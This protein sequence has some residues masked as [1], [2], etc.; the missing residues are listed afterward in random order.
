MLTQKQTI[1]V[2]RQQQN[3]VI[4]TRGSSGMGYSIPRKK[5][6][7]PGDF[8]LKSWD[9]Y[10]GIFENI[11]GFPGI[12]ENPKFLENFFFTLKIKK[13]EKKHLRFRKLF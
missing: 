5:N 4:M 6:P 2:R 9:P 11:P 3:S 7:N 10:P 12:P 8:E 13:N 1:E